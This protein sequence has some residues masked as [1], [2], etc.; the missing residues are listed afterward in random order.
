[1]ANGEGCKCGACGE[2]EC[3]CGCEI[4]WRSYREVELEEIVKKI[5]IALNDAIRRPM[6][7][8]PDSALEFVRT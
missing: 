6:G 4:D 7:V 3:G 8:V 2:C 1:M 5:T